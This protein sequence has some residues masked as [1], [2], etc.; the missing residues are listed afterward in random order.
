MVQDRRPQD[1]EVLVENVLGHGPTS[2]RAS[3]AGTGGR[4]D[5]AAALG[6]GNTDQK[7][8]LVHASS[9]G[10]YLEDEDEDED[11]EDEDEEEDSSDDEDEDDDDDLENV[12][13]IEDVIVQ[14]PKTDVEMAEATSETK[15]DKHRSGARRGGKTHTASSEP[16]PPEPFFYTEEGAELPTTAVSTSAGAAT[17]TA[18]ATSSTTTTAKADSSKA[19]ERTHEPM[20]VDD[21]KDDKKDDEKDGKDKDKQ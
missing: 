2:D 7:G 15:K 1:D 12:V 3:A 5:L 14:S 21:K 20:D 18:T 11:D 19:K 10:A 17:T 9:I 8:E 6:S 4:S 13:E 16:N